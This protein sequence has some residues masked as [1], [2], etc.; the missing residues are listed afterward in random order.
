MSVKMLDRT[1][2]HKSLTNAVII[3]ACRRRMYD[4]DDPGLCLACGNEQGGCEGDAR[5]IVCES[6]GQP[7]VYGSEELLLCLDWPLADD[8]LPAKSKLWPAGKSDGD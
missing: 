5:R 4:L 1:K 3:D 8:V 7:Q 2:W 6:C